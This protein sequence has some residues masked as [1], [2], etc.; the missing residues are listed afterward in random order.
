MIILI[1]LGGVGD[2]FKKAGYTTPKALIQIFGKPVL[3]YLLDNLKLNNGDLVYIPYNREY[4]RYFFENKLCRDYPDIEFQFLKLDNDTEGAAETINIALSNITV[5]DQPILCLDGDN[6]YTIDIIK[7]WD[8]ANKIFT[9]AEDNASGIFSYLTTSDG[10]ATN[11]VEKE[12]ISNYAC[13]GAYGFAS[14]K[15]LLKYTKIIIDGDIRRKNEFYTSTAIQEMINDGFKFETELIDRD[16]WKCLG[17]PIHV[18]KFC[19][20]YPKK[21]FNNLLTIKTLRVC[22]DLDNTLVTHPKI[23]G[24]YSTVEPIQKNIDFLKYLKGF[25]HT[26][27]I[28]TARRMK[29]HQGNIGKVL[30]DV[31]P[32]TFLTLK[33][34]DIPFDEIYFGK[35]YAHYYIDDLAINC[36]DDMEKLMGFYLDTVTPRSFNQLEFNT[37]ETVTKKSDDLSGEIYYYNNI[38]K[39]I[40]DLFP[41]FIDSSLDNTWYKIEKISGITVT[42]LYLCELLTIVNLHNIMNSIKRMQE[43]PIIESD[44][45]IYENYCS[46][47]QSRYKSFD[48]S[49][50]KDSEEIYEIIYSK[51][52][53]Y[54]KSDR[55][56]MSVIHGDTVMTNILINDFGKI[57]LI[58]MRGKIGDKL[59]IYGDWLYDWAKLYQSLIG[60]D[61][62]LQNK[63]LSRDYEKKMIDIF[64]TYFVELYS[65]ESFEDLKWI[66]NSL[67]FTLIPL[68]NNSKCQEYYK[69]IN[70]ES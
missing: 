9:F 7:L 68:H 44:I 58:D 55:G 57:K 11:I 47:L 5:H 46:K 1:P 2:R 6:F 23:V 61:K 18:R 70:I 30:C 50:Y 38:P 63:T 39:K 24:D 3:Y 29:T 25:G 17:T 62:I 16:S 54:E 35:P 12:A 42:S 45:N 21:S 56:K 27:I 60:Y 53:E 66:T 48:Y 4:S 67:L 19:N 26:I 37:I 43:V 14:Y 59:S 20:N 15:T 36:Y 64:E 28:Y 65:Q 13:T 10:I 32:I 41:I 49:N 51:L 69:L 31:G 22:F 52:L 8:G 40:K 33:K 34:Y